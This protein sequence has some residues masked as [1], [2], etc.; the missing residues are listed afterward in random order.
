MT[1]F[2]SHRGESDD[3][4][5][6]TITAFRLAVERES[7]GIELDL[8]LTADDEL[9]CAH[10]SDLRRVAG[11]DVTVAAATLAELRRFY[12][13]PRLSEVL[14]LLTPAIQLQMELKGDNPALPARLADVLGAWTGDC[15]RLSV[16]SFERETIRAAADFLS[17]LPR[18]LLTELKESDGRFP[19]PEEVAA[20]LRSLQCTGISF[21]ASPAADAEFVRKLHESGFRVVCW[22]V[23]T[24][25]LGLKMASCGVD[26][27]T[28]NH[29]VALR[30]QW[31]SLR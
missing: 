28:C 9:V 16:S 24:D 30:R 31:R 14:A 18:L 1:R 15:S 10:D 7:D 11:A 5:E 13:V 12:P 25:E 29:A 3:A 23:F 22:G 4:P 2:L 21:K 19:P 8:R 17:E 26:A 20:E 27:M 6:N